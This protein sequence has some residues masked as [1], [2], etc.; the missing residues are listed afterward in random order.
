MDAYPVGL[1][2]RDERS[3]SRRLPGSRLE[4]S[5]ACCR[6]RPAS[7][8]ANRKVL[9]PQVV[10]RRRHGRRLDAGSLRHFGGLDRPVVGQATQDRENY[11][12]TRG[13][14]T[15]ARKDDAA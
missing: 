11:G 2:E 1:K 14:A 8:A 3:G 13:T 4:F 7:V 10:Q 12:S 15:V 5:S 6:Q 9:L